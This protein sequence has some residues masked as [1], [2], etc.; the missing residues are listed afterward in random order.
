MCDLVGV[1]CL[2]FFLGYLF[3][4]TGCQAYSLTCQN[5][6]KRHDRQPSQIEQLQEEA[7]DIK[8]SAAMRASVISSKK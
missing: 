2:V 3:I 8:Y 4:A 7:L 6:S 5:F 1:V